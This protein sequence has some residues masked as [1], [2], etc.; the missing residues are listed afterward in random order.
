MLGNAYDINP[1]RVQTASM[2][3]YIV[4][5][6]SIQSKKIRAFSRILQNSFCGLNQQNC[7]QYFV[8]TFLCLK[9]AIVTTGSAI[10]T[11]SSVIVTKSINRY[12]GL[13]RSY[14]I[15][16]FAAKKAKLPE[17]IS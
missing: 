11:M 4:L 10:V 2:Y 14:K 17:S 5:H 7:L 13:C 16:D 12:T 6:I 9:R 1:H 15:A 3:F 8:R